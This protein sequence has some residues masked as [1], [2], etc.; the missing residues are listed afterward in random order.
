MGRNL[1]GAASLFLGVGNLALHHQLVS[2]W[3]LPG[4]TV[5]NVVTSIAL[6]LGGVALQFRKT[7]PPGAITLGGTYLLF[8]LT[9]V[10][11]IFRQPL[12]YASWGNVFYALASVAGAM[13]A[14]GVASPSAPYARM[15]CNIATM[16]LGVCAASFAVEQVEFL[17]RTAQLVPKWMPPNQMFWAIATTIAFGAAAVSLVSGY[18]ALPASRLLTLMLVIFAVAV[19]V[20]ALVGAP[21]TLSNWSEGLQTLSIAGAAWVVADFLHRE[22]LG[23]QLTSTYA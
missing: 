9:L 10:P 7:T 21:R 19:W 5:F 23:R 4:G 1:F 12:V 16:L 13:A 8:A 11:E 3:R 17:A 2:D 20:P 14:Y 22:A 15:L 18:K 6:I